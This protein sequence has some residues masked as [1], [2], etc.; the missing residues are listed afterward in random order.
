L[1]THVLSRILVP[2]VIVAGTGACTTER[3]GAPFPDP[4]LHPPIE[5]VLTDEGVEC[6]AVRGDDG[7]LYTLAAD[8]GRYRPGDRVCIVPRPVDISHCMQGV[9][10][11]VEW[12]GPAPCPGGSGD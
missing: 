7:T 2:I 6:P 3:G 10:V 9:T 1:V 12:I 5:G 4:P 11:M 8:L